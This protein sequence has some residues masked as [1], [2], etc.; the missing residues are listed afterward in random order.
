VFIAPAR[1]GLGTS[2]LFTVVLMNALY[3]LN[4]WMVSKHD[5]GR[6]AIR[7]EQ[8]VLTQNVGCQDYPPP[9]ENEP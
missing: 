1:S 8:E 5:L 6:Q 3:A 7:I 2:S 4:S 9:N